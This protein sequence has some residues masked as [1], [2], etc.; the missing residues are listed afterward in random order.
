MRTCVSPTPPSLSR[1][2]HA[3]VPQIRL[4]TK[5]LKHPA[6]P[7]ARSLR[8]VRADTPQREERRALCFAMVDARLRGITS[9]HPIACDASAVSEGA[10]VS[11]YALVVGLGWLPSRASVAARHALRFCA[12][13]SSPHSAWPPP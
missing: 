9:R 1:R 12:G 10:H 3:T 7:V 2:L 13:R 4:K 5:G 11:A 6:L 8:R